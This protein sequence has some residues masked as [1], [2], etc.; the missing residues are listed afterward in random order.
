MFQSTEQ[1][2]AWA[3]QLFEMIEMLELAAALSTSSSVEY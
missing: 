2:L 1:G 3:P